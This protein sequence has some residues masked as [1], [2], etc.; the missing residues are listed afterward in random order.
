MRLPFA[1]LLCLTLTGFVSWGVEVKAEDPA[2]PPAPAFYGWLEKYQNPTID[3]TIQKV[4]P[5]TAAQPTT[6]T[7]P[8]TLPSSWEKT[9]E[10]P[11]AALN[12]Q[13][14][15]PGEGLGCYYHRSYYSHLPLFNRK[16]DYTLHGNIDVAEPYHQPSDQVSAASPAA[17]R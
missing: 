1:T 14:A 8:I 7:A 13:V 11:D 17:P 5:Q 6:N 10:T 15:G 16:G 4:Q 2:A 3:R 9:V 12:G